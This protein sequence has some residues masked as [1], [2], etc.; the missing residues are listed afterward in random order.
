MRD[1]WEGADMCFD[2][3]P[4]VEENPLHASPDFPFVVDNNC[5]DTTFWDCHTEGYKLK[6]HVYDHPGMN[7]ETGNNWP[8]RHP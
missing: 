1:Y 2:N 8:M 6:V 7:L 5:Y 4:Y 3:S